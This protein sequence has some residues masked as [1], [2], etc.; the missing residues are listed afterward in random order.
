MLKTFLIILFLIFVSCSE[1][2]ETPQKNSDVAPEI[3]TLQGQ[4]DTQT[5]KFFLQI[6]VSD[7]DSLTDVKTV[8]CKFF[9]PESS[10]V[11]GETNLNNDGTEADI[12]PK[13][14]LWA[15]VLPIE[16]SIKDSVFSPSDTTK[17]FYEGFYRFEFLAEDFSGKKTTFLDSISYTAGNPPVFTGNFLPDTIQFTPQNGVTVTAFYPNDSLFVLNDDSLL[18]QIKATLSDQQGLQNIKS[19]WLTVQTSSGNLV[20][21]TLDDKGDVFK[22]DEIADDG[23]FTV[24][25]LITKSSPTFNFPL[26]FYA[27]DKNG[28][29]AEPLLDTLSVINFFNPTPS[30]SPKT[31]F[32]GIFE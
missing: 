12:L 8:S 15:V 4:L 13:D 10:T 11:F 28:L 23:T 26:V 17:I 1:N 24:K 7:Y 21:L 14:S 30:S 31:N 22:G 16:F 3:L 9:Q 32:G 27:L 2:I 19:V 25:L 29:A 18:F 5:G 6:K 20:T